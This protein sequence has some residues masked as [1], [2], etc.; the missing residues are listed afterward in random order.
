MKSEKPA[1]LL[2]CFAPVFLWASLS[3]FV[4]CF[5]PMVS[6]LAFALCA[7]LVLVVLLVVLFPFGRYDKKKGRTVLARPLF[8]RG[9]WPVKFLCSY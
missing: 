5:A 3:Y 8:V 4:G 7:S 9:L 1:N 2:D 6:A